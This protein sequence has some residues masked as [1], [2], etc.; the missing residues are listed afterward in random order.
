VK[1]GVE[2]GHLESQ[3]RGGLRWPRKY[4]A[5]AGITLF[6]IAEWVIVRRL[7]LWHAR[8]SESRITTSSTGRKIQ[9]FFRVI[10]V[11]RKR[12]GPRVTKAR[13]QAVREKKDRLELAL[14]EMKKI[15]A[16]KSGK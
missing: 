7:V 1:N 10:L 13:Q 4:V 11:W 5:I 8:S 6:L 14:S 2:M 16:M 12:W 3:R 9:F 15:R